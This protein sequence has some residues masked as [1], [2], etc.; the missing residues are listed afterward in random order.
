MA[1][2]EREAVAKSA[3]GRLRI[4]YEFAKFGGPQQIPACKLAQPPPILTGLDL[5]E[6]LAKMVPVVFLDVQ[7]ALRIPP[8]MS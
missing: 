6:I 2:E 3:Q 7:L 5:G 1:L 4:V 8:S